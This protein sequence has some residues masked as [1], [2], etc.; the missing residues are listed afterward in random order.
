MTFAIIKTGG[1]QYKVSEGDKLLIE[2]LDQEI[3][4]E[5]NFDEVLMVGNGDPKN[6]HPVKSGETGTAK[7]LFDGVKIGM[8][9]VGGA[10]VAAR[11]IDHGKGKKK[12]VFKYSNKTRYKK[13]KGHRQPFTQVE[14]LK[15][16]TS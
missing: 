2:K 4:K 3:G 9:L 5:F 11:V 1:K 10:S 14:I 15:I 12:I 16:T 6:V 13:K 7:Q 8:P